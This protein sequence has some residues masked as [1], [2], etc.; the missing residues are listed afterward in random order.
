M[1]RLF[2]SGLINFISRGNVAEVG[3]AIVV[4]AAFTR[5]IQTFITSFIIP[6]IS[7]LISKSSLEKLSFT[8]NGV[9]FSYGVFLDACLSFLIITLAVYYIFVMPTLWI[10][11][12][13]RQKRERQ[14]RECPACLG[15]IP[16]N[17]RRCGNCTSHLNPV[18]EVIT[19]DA[20]ESRTS[21][22]QVV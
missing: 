13:V 17:A 15:R 18:E 11:Q 6:V 3:V 12:V 19:D 2:G 1:G 7:L 5:V 4:G 14:E 10:M 22:V 21:I 16:K 9:G 8:I 20:L